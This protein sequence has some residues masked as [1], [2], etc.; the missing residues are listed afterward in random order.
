VTRMSPST[1]NTPGQGR[2]GSL[3]SPGHGDDAK[4]REGRSGATR[5]AEA[6]RAANQPDRRLA[7]LLPT[8]HTTPRHGN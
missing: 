6:P 3:A 1:A 4:A 7:V 5:H 8:P 2:A